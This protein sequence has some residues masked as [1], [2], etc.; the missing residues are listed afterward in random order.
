MS[1]L[2]SCLIYFTNMYL[3]M[4]IYMKIQSFIYK[5]RSKKLEK[6]HGRTR[7]ET[8]VPKQL[9]ALRNNFRATKKFLNPVPIL[10]TLKMPK[11]LHKS[12]LVSYL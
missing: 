11:S 1:C 5:T 10:D 4:V 8:N 9:L 6:G 2:M 12:P 3:N 7:K